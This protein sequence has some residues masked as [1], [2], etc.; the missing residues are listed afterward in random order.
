MKRGVGY[1]ENTECEEFSKGIFLLNHGITFHCPRC[2]ELGYSEPERGHSDNDYQIFREVH[3]HFN[4]E[5]IGKFY[6]EIAIVKDESLS[7]DG[8]NSYHLFSALIKTEVRALKV[9]E[10][11]LSNLNRYQGVLDESGIPKATEALLSFD[12]KLD[13]FTRHLHTLA[14]EW[15]ASGLAEK[16]ISVELKGKEV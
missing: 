7:E 10:A 16:K 9:A 2:R 5:P 8:F 11:I 6:R 4:Y 12:D 13:V 15:K 14:E 1:C 3:V